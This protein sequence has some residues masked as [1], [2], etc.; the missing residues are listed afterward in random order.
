MSVLNP[1]TDIEYGILG[2]LAV[3]VIGIF[4]VSGFGIV[5]IVRNNEFF[6]KEL[7]IFFSKIKEALKTTLELFKNIYEAISKAAK[8][9]DECRKKLSGD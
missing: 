9:V 7:E 3:L 2:I 5:S 8:Q 1:I 6:R 4:V